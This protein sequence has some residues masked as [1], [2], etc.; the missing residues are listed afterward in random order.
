MNQTLQRSHSTGLSHK[1]VSELI[2]HKQLS[3][4]IS[5]MCQPLC[6][7][8]GISPP[9]CK[10]CT[11]GV[12][13]FP[14]SSQQALEDWSTHGVSPHSPL[15][16]L[17]NSKNHSFWLATHKLFGSLNAELI[18]TSTILPAFLNLFMNVCL[19]TLPKQKTFF[20]PC[21]Q[22]SYKM[23]TKRAET[24]AGDPGNTHRR[25]LLGHGAGRIIPLFSHEPS[26]TPLGVG[27]KENQIGLGPLSAPFHIVLSLEMR[28]GLWPVQE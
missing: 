18:S 10:D 5:I 3:V 11:R 27:S 8:M 28:M 1:S 4:W 15:F 9:M 2:L 25:G 17:Q 19:Q 16:S 6:L 23:T 7:L 21:D 12:I 24:L 22:Q 14:Q 13:H 20:S 26:K